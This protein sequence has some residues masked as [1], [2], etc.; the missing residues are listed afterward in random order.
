VEIVDILI[1]STGMI[2]LIIFL[3]AIIKWERGDKE[4][5]TESE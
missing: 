1:E 3:D 4:I 2:V 5:S